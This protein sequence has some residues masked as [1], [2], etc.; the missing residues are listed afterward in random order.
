M[1]GMQAAHAN[2]LFPPFPPLQKGQGGFAF[3]APQKQILLDPPFAKGENT[4]SR[5]MAPERLPMIG[6]LKGILVHKQPPWVKR[7]ACEAL[8]RAPLNAR[9]WRAGPDFP[10]PASSRHGWPRLPMQSGAQ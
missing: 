6:R 8:P 3:H 1:A 5:L 7:R 10:K 4:P 9:P 2:A